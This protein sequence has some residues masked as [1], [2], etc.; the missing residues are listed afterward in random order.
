MN[1][2]PTIPVRTPA[3]L[4]NALQ[5]YRRLAEAT[6]AKIGGRAGIKQ[7]AVSTLETGAP[8]VRLSTLFRL[9]A[10]LDLELVVRKRKKSQHGPTA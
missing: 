1:E 6:Q 9:L 7:S 2:D 8:G 3:Q 4:G 5:R 10:A